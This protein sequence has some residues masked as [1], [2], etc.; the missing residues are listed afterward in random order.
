PRDSD[1]GWRL[2]GIYGWPEDHLKYKTWELMRQL[3]QVEHDKW[4]CI[5]DFN[6]VLYHHEK[7][8]GLMREDEKL[9]AFRYALNEC[10]LDDLGYKGFGYTWTNAQVGA[11]NIQERLD[12]DV[13]N[14]KWIEC[15][16]SFSVEHLIRQESDHNPIYITWEKSTIRIRGKKKPY[17]FEAMWLQE[18]SCNDVVEDTWRNG[19][20]GNL[21]YEKLKVVGQ[22]LKIWER[23]QFGHISSQIHEK[24]KLLAELQVKPLTESTS[25]EIRILEGELRSLIS[26]DHRVTDDMNEEM[27]KDYTKEEV[28]EAINQIHPL[29]A[30]GPDACFRSNSSYIWKS[31]I[32]GREILEYG[33][34]WNIRNGRSTRIWKDP[35]IPE[36][37]PSTYNERASA[38]PNVQLVCQLFEANGEYWNSELIENIFSQ[39][40]SKRILAIPL[41]QTSMEDCPFWRFNK[42]GIYSVKSGYWVMKGIKDA[43][44]SI[45]SVSSLSPN[46]WLWIWKLKIPPKIHIFLWRCMR[47]IIPSKAILLGRVVEV[48]PI[49]ERCGLEIEMTEHALRDC[50][51]AIFFWGASA[52]RLSIHL[53]LE[54][55][56]SL[57][58]WILK[59]IHNRDEDYI[60]T[61]ASHLWM[62]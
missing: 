4:L 22:A 42:N 8:G 16:P 47:G 56:V 12:R 35:W 29:K 34:N 27:T 28:V 31:L 54:R 23:Y 49:C 13:A 51:W 57:Q 41:C 38:F 30:P 53:D 58:D 59:V 52:L 20:Q 48:D 37:Y 36:S 14:S 18:T 9:M 39:D 1:Q 17:R 5:G 11:S 15:F 6:E 50:G 19:N 2:T 46:P 21:F 44:K 55:N 61:F 10:G 40:I 26:I 62:I 60:T 25:R 7:L 45:P 24:Q 32:A 3:K 43:K 33:L